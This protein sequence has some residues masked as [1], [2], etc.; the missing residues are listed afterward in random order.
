M[1]LKNAESPVSNLRW[2]CLLVA[3]A[4]SWGVPELIVVE[5]SPGVDHQ[6]LRRIFMV[7]WG[8]RV[9]ELILATIAK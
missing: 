2:Q 1:L 7:L 5:I 4:D 8:G 9:T 3:S 6:A